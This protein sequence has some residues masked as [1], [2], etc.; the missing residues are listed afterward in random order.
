MAEMV[1]VLDELG[2]KTIAQQSWPNSI[3]SR[4]IDQTDRADTGSRR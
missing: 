2:H 3:D 1:A 4:S